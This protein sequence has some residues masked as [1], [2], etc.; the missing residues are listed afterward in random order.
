MSS[1]VR[2]TNTPIVQAFRPV[3]LKMRAAP[4]S[5]NHVERIGE[6]HS[7]GGTLL[8]G[9]RTKQTTA[10]R[11]ARWEAVTFFDQTYEAW[12]ISGQGR[13]FMGV[14]YDPYTRIPNQV[15][16]SKSYWKNTE[17]VRPAFFH[18]GWRPENFDPQLPKL[19]ILALPYGIWTRPQ[20]PYEA[21][22][23]MTSKT[24]SDSDYEKFTS[25]WKKRCLH[26]RE[27]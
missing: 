19:A 27:R 17:F 7:L 2:E 23:A 22:C 4:C 8:I 26:F 18:R 15:D 16:L 20:L 14:E 21:R 11:P 10:A 1:R 9:A 12:L 5:Y 6:G 24:T 25:D 13:E 3:G